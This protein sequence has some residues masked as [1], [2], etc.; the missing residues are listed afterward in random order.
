MSDK[1]LIIDQ[2]EDILQLCAIIEEYMRT[3]QP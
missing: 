2:G 3:E 1:V